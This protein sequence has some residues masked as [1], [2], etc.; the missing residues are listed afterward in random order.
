MAWLKTDEDREQIWDTAAVRLSERSGRTGMG[1]IS[2]KFRIPTTTESTNA[3]SSLETV[4]ASG[5]E[6]DTAVEI[7]IHE[8]PMTS[9]NLGLKTWASSYVLA[10]KWHALRDDLPL[11]QHGGANEDRILE[12]GAGTGLVGI[13]AA[14]V[15]GTTVILTDLPEIVPNLERNANSNKLIVKAKKGST[16]TAVLDWTK[17]ADVVFSD[18]DHQGLDQ[19]QSA[20]PASAVSDISTGEGGQ[21]LSVPVIVAAD[22]IYSTDHPRLLAQAVAFHLHRAASS[23]VVV[24]IPI[25][26]AYAAERAD[27]RKQMQVVGLEMVQEDTD[28]GYDDWTE[29]SGEE[30]VEVECWMSV[31]AWKTS[32]IE[33]G[34]S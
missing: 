26:E 30:L 12:L 5:K 14:V 20:E 22:P 4:I 29:G 25:R 7:E 8:P 13:A 28:I 3:D 15:L 32:V 18:Q 19:R 11:S 33:G 27:F 17:P 2:R 34:G 21:G 24:T 31:W 16:Q 23:R 1:A 9:D 10:R 6:Q